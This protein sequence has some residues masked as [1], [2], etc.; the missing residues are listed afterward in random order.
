MLDGNENLDGKLIVLESCDGGGKSTQVK[1]IQ[2]YLQSKGLKSTFIHFPM[3]GDNEYSNIIE[4]FLRGE[5][6]S[7]DKVDPYFVANIY[8]MD[9]FLYKY[10]LGRMLKT[11]DIVLLD[12]YVYSNA[13]FQAAK[14]NDTDMSSSTGRTLQETMINWVLQLEFEFLDLP[15]PDLTLF[16]DVPI[17]I[18]E[19]RLSE[20]RTGED[21]EYLKGK[22][23]IHEADME[24]QSKVRDIY[25][26]LQDQLIIVQNYNIIDCEVMNELLTPTELFYSYK[27]HIDKAINPDGKN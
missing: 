1:I 9:R 3:Y 14:Y 19:E 25:L 13:A 15:R 10:K 16:L 21:R 8:A 18:V 23:D 7:I 20:E 24:F 2:K 6:G 27:T 5:Y 26:K 11:Y 12:R 17:N 22:Q 4:A